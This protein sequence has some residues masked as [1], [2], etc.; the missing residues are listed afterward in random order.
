MVNRKIDFL[1]CGTQKGGTSALHAYLREH[2]GICMANQKEVH[3]FDN[4]SY[5]TSQ[6]VDY[7]TYHA[8][9]SPNSSHQVL[10]ESTPIYMYW[11]N[12]PRR[13]WEYNPDIKLIIILRNPIERAYSHWNMERSRNAETLS[14]WDAIHKERERCKEALPY[15]HRVYS[16]IDRGFYLE[17]LRRLWLYFPR[18]QIII[19]KNEDLRSKCMH[20][21]KDICKFLEIEMFS[22]IGEKRVHSLSYNSQLTEKERKHL[23]F[24]YEYEIRGIE[25]CL[26][27]DCSNWRSSSK[28]FEHV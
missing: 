5:F 1:I 20:T 24:I 23:Q 21:L 2:P 28:N 19:I 8:Q 18:G 26:K 13:I 17:Q 16:Y 3:F 15:Q 27:W 7:S 11:H 14:F 22:T 4:E 12:A 9:F 25:R 6:N 10:G